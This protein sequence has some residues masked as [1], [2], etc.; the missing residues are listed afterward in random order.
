MNTPFL[1]QVA[2]YYLEVNNLEDYCFVF[3]NRRSGQ[4]FVHYLSQQLIDADRAASRVKPHL[5]PCVTS[6]NELVAQLTGTTTA[7]DI[8]MI[9]AL[10]DAYCQ[11]FGDKA[12]EF[13]KFVY[14][15]QLIIGDFNDIDKSLNDASEIFKNLDDL[16]SL[17]SNYLT[18][19]VLEQVRAIFGES[20]FTSF[21]DTG[22]DADLWR[23]RDNTVTGND[24]E[25]SRVKREFMTL[26][27]ALSAIYDLY[28]KSLE[29]KGV[30][31]PGMQLRKVAQAATLDHRFSRL[32]FVGFGVL[33]A[34]EV[35]LFDHFKRDKVADFWW[36]NAGIKPLLDMAPHDPGALLIDGYCKR[37]EAKPVE[38]VDNQG[39]TL[40]VVAV[41]STVGQAKQAFDE[42]ALMRG[43]RDK[44]KNGVDTA[45]VLPD[46]SLLVPLLHSVHDVDVLNVTLG[47]PLRSSGIVSL[48][49]IVAR[50]HHQASK[51]HGS[52]TYYREDV[53]DI[54]SHPLIKTFFTNEALKMASQLYGTHR[55]RVP[56]SE[57]AHLSFHDLFT[58]AVDS[59]QG[60]E[61]G[62]T[63]G[64]L[65]H[66][67]AF[68]NLLMDR[69]NAVASPSDEDLD[70]EEE[71]GV[72][73][74]LQQAFL[75]MYIDVLN[76]L[77]HSLAELGQ[78]LQR[79]SVFYLIDRLSA[80]S[81]VPFTGEPIQGLQVMGLL[82]TRS[83]DF[84]NVVVL[85]MNERVFP[86]R[87]G[88]NSFIPNYIRRAHGMSTLEQ[89]EA[90]V[91]FNF[92]RLLNRAEH[93]SL[94]YDSSVKS[95]GS[96]EPSRY[97]A[98]L[99]KVYGRELVHVEMNPVVQT[100]SS[101]SIKLPNK[102]YDTLRG[103]YLKQR[104]HADEWFLSASAIKKYIGCPLR[105]YLHYFQGLN[106]DTDA[107]DFMDSGTFGTII[108]DTLND[109][110]AG[111]GIPEGGRLIDK[112]YIESFQRGRLERSVV[113]NIKRLYLHVDKDKLAT[114]VSPLRG[115]AFMLMDTIK[116]YV[117]FVLNYDKDLID[118]TGGPF[119]VLECELTHDRLAMPM[120]G[121][122]FNFTYKPDRVDRLADGTVRIVDYKTGNE[123][124]LFSTM[125]DLFDPT[126]SN[127]GEGILQVM[128]YCYAYLL[129][130]KEL[131]SVTP[132]IYKVASMKESGVKYKPPGRGTVERQV[133]FSMDDDMCRDYIARMAGTI[134]DIFTKDF[135]QCDESAGS[136]RY[137]RFIDFC[138]RAV[139]EVD[140]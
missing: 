138:R 110:Y 135:E 120:G 106:E 131:S 82:E 92:Y 14:W 68:C 79:S 115:E 50:M 12:Q 63:I 71:R 36:D 69:M 133:V 7:T 123:R 51:E 75:V 105:F 38:P 98:Q 137:C 53:Y 73:L 76:Q 24:K 97:I 118:R 29:A 11:V 35:K 80:S 46:E 41:P 116:G 43:N 83:L 114:D 57:F 15:A 130:K 104:E 37:F 28:H 93:V 122:K 66:L 27:N 89:Q 26:W 48:M 127:Q 100:S 125:D 13:D 111:D 18:P 33:S 87:K 72:K 101:T 5:L 117:N 31:S 30:V 23:Q 49:H 21:F 34:A 65:D 1:Q 85:S 108:H 47:Y 61:R 121:V 78:A 134:G 60:D 99:E 96:G 4:F 8:E 126:N 94:V 136:C 90:I 2:R 45:V 74:P 124:M 3:P 32:V 58:P 62:Q 64:Y 9:F 39:Q 40:R 25:D 129:E 6:V 132:V 91:S 139:V 140:Y 22:A 42:V 107:G 128:L 70:P 20:L 81:V 102:G 10:Y 109:C 103:M 52:W 56:A 55:F 119:T 59:E 84:K 113:R 86:R 17:S 88:I 16:H 44:N 54:L 95:M 19:E 77:K 112:G 67:L